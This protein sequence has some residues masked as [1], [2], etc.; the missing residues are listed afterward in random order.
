M[1]E[2]QRGRWSPRLGVNVS[3]LWM[4]L[5][6]IASFGGCTSP[7]ISNATN[8]GAPW[9]EWDL[10]PQETSEEEWS[11]ALD[12]VQRV[13]EYR[14]VMGLEPVKLDPRLTLAALNQARYI[15]THYGTSCLPRDLE[16]TNK[17]QAVRV[18]LQALQPNVRSHSATLNITSRSVLVTA[19]RYTV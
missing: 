4:I 18:T 8:A 3:A 10:I 17:C 2:E 15:V 9:E 11:R 13:N 12:G 1:S 5:T 16:R 19:T 7:N 14:A 6:S